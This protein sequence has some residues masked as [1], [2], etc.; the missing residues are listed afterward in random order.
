MSYYKINAHLILLSLMVNGDKLA[1]GEQDCCQEQRLVNEEDE[2]NK[3]LLSLLEMVT[4]QI[5]MPDSK[6]LSHIDICVVIVH[7]HEGNH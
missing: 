2:L 5:L 7:L 1:V 3:D 4:F 6:T